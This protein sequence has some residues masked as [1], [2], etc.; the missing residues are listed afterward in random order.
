M[1]SYKELDKKLSQLLII[2]RGNFNANF[3]SITSA[4][5]YN[6]SIIIIIIKNKT[7]K[8]LHI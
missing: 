4:L 6:K 3:A 2:M 7:F 5:A 8:H 1:I